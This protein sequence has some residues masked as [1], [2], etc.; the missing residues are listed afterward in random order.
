M[1]NRQ[2]GDIIKELRLK[3]GLSQRKLAEIVKLSNT[4]I[5]D[6]EKNIRNITIDNLQKIAEALDTTVDE[7]MRQV[8]KNQESEPK[9]VEQEEPSIEDIEKFLEGRKM[10]AFK[11][12]VLTEEQLR[13][14]YAFLI[15]SDEMYKKHQKKLDTDPE[16]RKD[17]EEKVKLREKIIEEAMYGDDDDEN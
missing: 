16:Y 17:F 1:A 11:G 14:V 13:S 2:I 5:S 10:L 7:I 12:Q 3:K 15:A 9:K 6:I 4:T 8:N